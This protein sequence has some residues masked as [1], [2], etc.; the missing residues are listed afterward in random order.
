[1]SLSLLDSGARGLRVEA[2][3]RSERKLSQIS[4]RALEIRSA[5][6]SI[7]RGFCET[8]WISG[9]LMA[10]LNWLRSGESAKI[11][12]RIELTR[13]KAFGGPR[14]R[15]W[16]PYRFRTRIVATNAELPKLLQFQFSINRGPVRSPACSI[17]AQANRIPHKQQR[18][19]VRGVTSGH[20]CFGD[21]SWF[22]FPFRASSTSAHCL[23]APPYRQ[24]K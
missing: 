14:L 7:D 23:R 16:R 1:M 10:S 6:S 4:G 19:P 15:Q 5:I 13:R 2:E 8:T 17:T 9:F 3:N 20:S 22:F 18:H 24:Q 11:F 21:S 12:S